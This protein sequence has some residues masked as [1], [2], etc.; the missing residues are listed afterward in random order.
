[1]K[2]ELRHSHQIFNPYQ[3]TIYKV[4]SLS[5]LMNILPLLTSV[6]HPEEYLIKKTSSFYSKKPSSFEE[7]A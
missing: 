1:M 5:N 7:M 4:L 6:K 3:D 2:R